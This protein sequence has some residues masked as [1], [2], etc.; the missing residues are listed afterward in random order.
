M[1]RSE[2]IMDRSEQIMDRSEQIMDRS[3]QIM[4]RSRRAG[5]GQWQEYGHVACNKGQY[6]PHSR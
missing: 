5:V 3:E 1:D 2:Q 6:C 4:D